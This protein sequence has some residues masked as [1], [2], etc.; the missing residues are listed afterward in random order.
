V[1]L[2]TPLPDWKVAPVMPRAIKGELK[3]FGYMYW[4]NVTAEEVETFY[5]EQMQ[6]N[7]WPLVN[8]T[9]VL[10]WYGRGELLQFR[11][12]DSNEFFDVI[13][14]VN[15]EDNSM[16]IALKKYLYKP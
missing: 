13:F 11:Q 10:S 15:T 8:H 4:A 9:N 16:M 14:V 7:G 6:L 12:E 5:T 3:G 2:G 1:T